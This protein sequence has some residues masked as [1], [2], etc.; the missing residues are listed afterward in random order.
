MGL[1]TTDNTT[2]T[3]YADGYNDAGPLERPAYELAKTKR[4]CNRHDDCDAADAKAR[5]AAQ[6]QGLRPDHHLHFGADHCH[7]ECCEECFGY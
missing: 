2:R 6:A 5:A 3:T 1:M 7:D 4:Q